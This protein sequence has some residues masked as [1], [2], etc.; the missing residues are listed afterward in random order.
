[1]ES[2]CK[3]VSD[4]IIDLIRSATAPALGA[5]IEVPE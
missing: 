5:A 2:I 1:M 4:G 3:R